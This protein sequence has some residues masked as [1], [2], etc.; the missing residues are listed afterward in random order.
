MRE[1]I[2]RSEGGIFVV[3]KHSL[4]ADRKNV[5]APIA[6][7]TDIYAGDRWRAPALPIFGFK[8]QTIFVTPSQIRLRIVFALIGRIRQLLTS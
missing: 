6:V 2:A 7:Q 1:E 5:V 8:R 3:G 4:Q